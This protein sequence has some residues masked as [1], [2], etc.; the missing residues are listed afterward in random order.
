M[1]L[2]SSSLSQVNVVYTMRLDSECEVCG[3]NYVEFERVIKHR[4]LAVT[5]YEHGSLTSQASHHQ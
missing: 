4:G 3:S 5:G 2:L 1:Q